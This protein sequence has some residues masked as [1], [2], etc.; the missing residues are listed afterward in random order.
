MAATKMCQRRWY[1]DE[2]KAMRVPSGDQR[3]STF[4]APVAGTARPVPVARSSSSSPM[5]SCAER[6]K[7]TDRPSL[8]QSGWESYP[9]PEVSCSAATEPTRWR[10]NHP[11]IEYTSSVPSGDHVTALGPLVAWGT[12][13]SRQ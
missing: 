12:Y 4:T 6:A 11:R 2:T 1:A 10:H 13:I 3:G 8:D 7:T 5:A 9:G